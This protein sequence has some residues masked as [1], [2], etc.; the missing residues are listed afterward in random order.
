MDN[1]N[2]TLCNAFDDYQL[3]Q[4]TGQGTFA[5][6]GAW[7]G[8]FYPFAFTDYAILLPI[9]SHGIS[10]FAHFT[11][12]C[13]TMIIAVVAMFRLLT[14]IASYREALLETALLGCAAGFMQ[15][16]MYCIFS[17]RLEFLIIALFL[18]GYHNLRNS[19]SSF[20]H[21]LM[22][23]MLV[24]ATYIKETFFVI[25]TVIALTELIFDNRLKQKRESTSLCNSS[26]H[27]YILE[28]IFHSAF[29]KAY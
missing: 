4:K 6:G 13:V 9:F 3:F 1:A 15:I 22:F 27:F 10:V 11:F 18:L 14:R 5:H 7:G 26:Q 17:E 19:D 8:R 20:G 29:Y 25:S 12:N 16:Q 23:L 21:V 28:Y 2:W 24:L